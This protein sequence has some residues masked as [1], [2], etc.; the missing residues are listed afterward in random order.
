ME[1]VVADGVSL[2]SYGHG[3]QLVGDVDVVPGKTGQNS[4]APN[5]RGAR[6]RPKRAGE[7]QRVLTMWA[8][9]RN[10]DG[11]YP[12][13]GLARRARL[14][15]NLR[16]LA[17]LFAKEDAQIDLTRTVLVPSVIA[18][19]WATETWTARCESTR[20]ITFASEDNTVE[21]RRFAVELNFPDPF[22]YGPAIVTALG[23][24]STP[25]I[26]PGEATARAM[27][28]TLTGGSGGWT[29]P[30]VTIG[31]TW[32][33]YT[34]VLGSGQTLT[35]DTDAG[36]ALLGSTSV[37]GKIDHAAVADLL[38][39]PRGTSDV[40]LSGGGGDGTGQLTFKPPRT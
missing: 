29:N 3:I 28:L 2:K 31:G 1:D 4:A 36:T 22:W 6:W 14:N 30:M 7:V 35:I 21:E 34:A 5:R 23:L 24:G 26:N 9:G 33:R 11:T 18:P 10:A 17:A 13:N 25:V 8:D 12:P 19:W 16:E 40:V 27:T 20:A 32:L 38:A 37:L 15:A 39:L